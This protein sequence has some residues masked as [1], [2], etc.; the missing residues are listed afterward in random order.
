MPYSN[1]SGKY[2]ILVKKWYFFLIPL[3]EFP[4]GVARYFDTADEA[5][6]FLKK[7]YYDNNTFKDK[8]IKEY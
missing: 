2:Y 6:N 8:I 5:E 3:W 7:N 4:G 1:L